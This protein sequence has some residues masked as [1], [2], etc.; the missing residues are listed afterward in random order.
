MS[1]RFGAPSKGLEGSIGS[2]A[3][4]VERRAGER[5]GFERRAQ[6]RL[7][8]QPAAGGVEQE[9]RRLHAR[10]QRRGRR[11]RRSAAVSGQCRLTTSAR[12]KR[13]D[14]LRVRSRG[15]ALRGHHLHAEG[16]RDLGDAAPD[17]PGADDSHRQARELDSGDFQNEKSGERLHSPAATA[18]AWSAVWLQSSSSS[19]NVCCATESVPYSGTLETG[20]VRSRARAD[21]DHVVA[22]SEHRDEAQR[23]QCVDRRAIDAGLVGEEDLGIACPLDDEGGRRA[24]E[25]GEIAEACHRVP[26]IVARIEGMAVEDDEAHGYGRSVASPVIGRLIAP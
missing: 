12:A 20:I 17:A 25:H 4:D 3:D 22:G 5:A 7:V 13:S 6:S 15:R 16:A 18:A 2:R 19:A 9:R 23:R 8:D 26:R 11:S 24:V 21:V 14:E 1:T 10:E